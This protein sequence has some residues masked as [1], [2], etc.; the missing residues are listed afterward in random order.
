MFAGVGDVLEEVRRPVTDASG[1]FAAARERRSING[2]TQC[3]PSH[4]RPPRGHPLPSARCHPRREPL[5]AERALCRRRARAATP[6]WTG[7]HY[8]KTDRD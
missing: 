4:R 8:A 2:A 5:G 1:G 6:P 3:R 7:G